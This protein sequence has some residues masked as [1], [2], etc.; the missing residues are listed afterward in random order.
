M[1]LD[2]H[3]KQRDIA[4]GAHILCHDAS[5]KRVLGYTKIGAVNLS[6]DV[7]VGAQAV[8]L[9]GVTVGRG[10]IVAAGSV[11]TSPV[12]DGVVVGGVPARVLCTTEEY[13]K[14]EAENLKTARIF[15][16][17]YAYR[18]ATPPQKE[19]QDE[20]RRLLKDTIGYI[21]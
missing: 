2:H 4:P 7:F 20:Q 3:R 1:P 9:P 13:F 11:V 14:K 18:N 16:A 21:E 19:L 8:I 10:S 15:D 17:R 6:D 12:A 5:T